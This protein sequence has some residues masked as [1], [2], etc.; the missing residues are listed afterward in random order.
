MSSIGVGI[1][2][3][4]GITLQNHLPGL[5]LCP[6]V[7]VVALCDANAE[8]VERARQDSPEAACCSDYREILKRDAVHAVIIATPNYLH[9]PIA[10]EAVKMG[11][12]VFCEKP[13]AMNFDEARRMYQAAESARV[14]HMTAFTY[15][16]VPAMRFMKHLVDQGAVGQPYH[17]RNCRLQD[18]GQR[19]L[20]WRQESKSAGSGELG[21]M[22]SHRIDFA[23]MLFGPMTSLVGHT[24]IYH[25]VR[26]GRPSDLEDWAAIICD[27]SIGATGVFESSKIATGNNE[28]M[29]S[30]DYVE[31]NGSDG[32]LRY[33]TQRPRELHI[34]K[35]GDKTFTRTEVPAEFLSWPGSPRD[36]NQGDP[37]FVFRYDQNF[38]FIDAIRNQRRCF[39]S[40][41]DGALVQGVIDAALRSENEKRWVDVSHLAGALK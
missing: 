37:L 2:G 8:V 15:R 7:K 21:D 25:P 31:L 5:A 16:F 19:H 17:F 22:L 40:F 10:V 26:D 11:K 4:G 6:E 29:Y 3:C 36:P 41:Y 39:A 23:H 24:R 18:W 12:H 9:E 30:Q 32:S 34:A 27:F 33:D 14:R 20:G 35:K 28:S 1:I 38:E 13:L